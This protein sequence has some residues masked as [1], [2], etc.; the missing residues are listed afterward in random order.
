MAIS[1]FRGYHTGIH[2]VG[3]YIEVA[4]YIGT[5]GEVGVL[6]W[7]FS[8]RPFEA[9][10]MSVPF[11]KDYVRIAQDIGVRGGLGV[12]QWSFSPKKAAHHTRSRNWRIRLAVI[13]RLGG[14]CVSCGITD[15][16]IL[17][18]NHKNGG[19]SRERAKL[20]A[21]TLETSIVNGDRHTDD[22]D[23]RCANCNILYEYQTGRRKLPTWLEPGEACVV[24]YTGA[25]G[26]ITC[27]KDRK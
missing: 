5:T 8:Q 19:G 6:Q 1:A 2:D 24:T 17:Q 10:V 9:F 25:S 12:L 20:T 14:K 22:L 26:S 3:R 21:W 13:S 15:P 7:G 4:Q 23:L 27:K 16:R 18:I 11:G